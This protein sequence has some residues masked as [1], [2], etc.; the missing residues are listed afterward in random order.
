MNRP[1][2]GAGIVVAAVAS[3]LGAVLCNSM[4][5]WLPAEAIF[6]VLVS[7][8]GFAYA[9][10]LLMHS[11]EAVGRVLVVLLWLLMSLTAWVL[12]SSE[13]IFLCL[14]LGALW[15]LRSLYYYSSALCALLD[16]ALCVF[17]LSA[18]VAAALHTGSYFLVIWCFFAGQAF[19]TVIPISVRRPNEG[20]M[21]RAHDRENFQRA[22]RTAEAA[23]RRLSTNEKS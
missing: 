17:S 1:S 6:R 9:M 5:A 11:G 23:I 14:H 3:L 19:F 4:V 8:L 16:L 7:G 20:H 22:F 2:L 15:L 21:V 13:P 12:V 18:A 10:Y